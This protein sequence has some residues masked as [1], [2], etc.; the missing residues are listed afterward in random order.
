MKHF[1][2]KEA[3]KEFMEKFVSRHT[4]CLTL[5]RVISVSDGLAMLGGKVDKLI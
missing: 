5:S 2:K 1:I 4:S 3:C